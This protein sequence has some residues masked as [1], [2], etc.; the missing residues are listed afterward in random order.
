[1]VMIMSTSDVVTED[2]IATHEGPPEIQAR[3]AR[4]IAIQTGKGRGPYFRDL[5]V[6]GCGHGGGGGYPKGW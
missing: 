5:A 4:F 3:D 6:V 2:P 1:M